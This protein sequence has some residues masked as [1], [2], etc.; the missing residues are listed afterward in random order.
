MEL[1]TNPSP[2]NRVVY[3][4]R[5][6]PAGGCLSCASI[7]VSGYFTDENTFVEAENQPISLD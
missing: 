1:L 6:K 3:S 7:L 5:I 4:F 2:K